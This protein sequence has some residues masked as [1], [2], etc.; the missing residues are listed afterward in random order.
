MEYLANIPDFTSS[1]SVWAGWGIALV[2]GY[3][4]AFHAWDRIKK[5]D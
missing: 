4:F 3:V 2:V 5:K 1:Y